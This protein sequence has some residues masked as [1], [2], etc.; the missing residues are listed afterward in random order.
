[1]AEPTIA[2][3]SILTVRPKP[4]VRPAVLHDHLWA[5]LLIGPTILGLLVFYV[6]PV[7]YTIYLSLTQSGAFGKT[8]WN[9]IGNY[10]QLIHDPTVWQSFANTTIY[11][12]IF[13]PISII[14][15][16]LVAV[17]LNQKM[18]GRN[19]Y[20]T[21][22]FLPVVTAPA[23]ISMIWKWMYNGQYGLI[24]EF[25]SMFHIHGLDWTTNPNV[26]IF[27]VIVV[28]IW[29]SIGYNMVI[30]LAGLQ[31]ISSTYY[32]AAAIDGAGPWVKFYRITL[33]LLSPTIFFLTVISLIGAFQVFDVIYMMIGQTNPALPNTESLVYL[34]YYTGFVTDDQSYAST[35]ATILFVFILILTV[36]QMSLQK[37]WV[38]YE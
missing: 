20:R 27:S 26:A 7:F 30:F 38:H 35:I 33:P 15:S 37:R 11:A 34:F 36:I 3:P 5:Y 8:S 28:G 25:L 10:I 19:I 23:A 13:V 22:Y 6:A 29:G 12:V 4:R 24:N 32:E 31:G 18:N 2:Q 16:I 21:I 1:M 9:G 17:L 14:S